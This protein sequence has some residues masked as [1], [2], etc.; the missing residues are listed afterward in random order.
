MLWFASCGCHIVRPRDRAV[1]ALSFFHS[2]SLRR[3]TDTAAVTSV[4]VV[5]GRNLPRGGDV[6]LS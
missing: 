6:W 2:W 1:R 5:A 3:R 4:A